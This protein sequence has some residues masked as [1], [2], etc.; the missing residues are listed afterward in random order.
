MAMVPFEP[1]VPPSPARLQRSD[2]VGRLGFA[3]GPAGARLCD[4]YQSDPVRFLF[5]RPAPGEPTTAV[6][7]TT[8]GGIA[9]GD[10]IALA[11]AAD[12]GVVATVTTQAAEKVYRSLGPDAHLAASVSVGDGGWLEWLPQETILFDG[13]RLRRRTDLDVAA[14]GRVLALE[15]VVFGRIARGEAF[16]RGALRE[17]WRVRV[18][19]RPAWADALRLVEP[20]APLFAATAG[21]AGARALATLVHVGPA[22]AAAREAVRDAADGDD[23]VRVGAS[24]IGPV[25][26]A[27][28]L[29]GDAQILRRAVLRAVGAVRSR[30]A[31]LPE[32][33][34]ELWYG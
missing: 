8:S 18:D 3:A 2:G 33:L 12:A 20:L 24:A 21:L 15:M 5:P 25:M 34:P 1:P 10:R 13:A 19:G 26:V 16:T 11:M 7:V 30:L 22:A 23:G 28:F 29:G 9:G 27:R 17:D 31:G 32:R 6:V 4:L 14:G